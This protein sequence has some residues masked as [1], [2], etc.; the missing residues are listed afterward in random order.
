MLVT[1]A[2]SGRAFEHADPNSVGDAWSNDETNIARHV[3]GAIERQRDASLGGDRHVEDRPLPSGDTRAE[4]FGK[5]SADEVR[6]A[7]KRQSLTEL[8]IRERDDELGVVTVAS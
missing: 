5:R 7:G 6:Q 3:I 2:L 1:F 4:R 8:L